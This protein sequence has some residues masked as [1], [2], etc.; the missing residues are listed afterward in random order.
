MQIYLC[1]MTCSTIESLLCMYIYYKWLGIRWIYLIKMLFVVSDINLTPYNIENNY[2]DQFRYTQQVFMKGPIRDDNAI[3]I[4]CDITEH[5]LQSISEYCTGLQSLSLSCCKYITDTG[6]VTICMHCHELKSWAV[7]GCQQIT[8]TSIISMSTHC[9]GLQL[10]NL[11]RCYLNYGITNC[12]I[13]IIVWNLTQQI[14]DKKACYVK[15][16]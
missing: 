12:P 1:C 5:T 3:D 8:N 14:W 4:S 13:M 2:V 9:I 6:L 11:E 10:L 16:T 7:M 15:L